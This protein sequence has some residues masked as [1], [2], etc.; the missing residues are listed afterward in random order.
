MHRSTFERIVDEIDGLEGEAYFRALGPLVHG[1]E[2]TKTVLGE[3]GR[4]T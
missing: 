3:R 2:F 4:L 1:R